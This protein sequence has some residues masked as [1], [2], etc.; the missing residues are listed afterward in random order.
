MD[1]HEQATTNLV[2]LRGSKPDDIRRMMNFKKVQPTL[3]VLRIV[4]SLYFSTN[5]F[6]YLSL[7][8]ALTQKSKIAGL[9][10]GSTEFQ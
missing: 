4:T 1:K 10:I 2:T 7:L 6:K 9:Q 8:Q 5:A 3:A